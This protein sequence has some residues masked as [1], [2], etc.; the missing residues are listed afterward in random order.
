MINYAASR[1]WTF[2]SALFALCHFFHFHRPDLQY[3]TWVS[4]AMWG[5]LCCYY[6]LRDL[7]DCRS[8][9]MISHSVLVL[10]LVPF[11]FG[12]SFLTSSRLQKIVTQINHAI[13]AEGYVSFE[14]KSIVHNYGD[15]I[16]ESL[17]TGVCSIW[18]LTIL[19]LLS[20]VSCLQLNPDIIC[21]DIGLC[22]NIG[23]NIMEYTFLI[24]LILIL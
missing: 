10:F 15:S 6:W 22:S 4:R 24:F 19:Y 17:I 12:V 16:W 3:K 23:F 5:W 20:Y 7:F 18:I 11:L 8:N 1:I 2:L 13:G 14:C 9:S 21:S